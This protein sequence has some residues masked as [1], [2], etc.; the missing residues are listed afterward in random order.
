MKKYTCFFTIVLLVSV[1][2][3][4]KSEEKEKVETKKK[5]ELP[6]TEIKNG[7]YTEYYPERKAVKIRGAVDG[8]KLREG[9]WVLYSER[10]D[11]MSVTSYIHGNK[12][13][14]TFVKYPT[15]AMNYVGEYKNDKKVGL[16]TFYDQSGKIIQEKDFGGL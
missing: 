9:R 2:F 1:L 14:A 4:C 16:W 6:L 3:S 8:N 11:E 7:I 5:K 13:G 10:G 12:N 15:G